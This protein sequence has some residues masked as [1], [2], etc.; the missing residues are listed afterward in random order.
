M[1]WMSVYG[2]ESHMTNINHISSK[3]GNDK[4]NNHV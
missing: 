1:F 2:K 3:I 4:D